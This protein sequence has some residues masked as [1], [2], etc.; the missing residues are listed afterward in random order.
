M[1]VV[2]VNQT[3][4][5][6][7]SRI[8]LTSAG[9]SRS[10]ARPSRNSWPTRWARLIASRTRWAHE[11]WAVALRDGD[12]MGGAAVEVGRGLALAVGVAGDP[13]TRADGPA[14]APTRLTTATRTALRARAI[15]PPVRHVLTRPFCAQERTTPATAGANRALSRSADRWFPPALLPVTPARW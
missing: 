11:T 10:S 7:S 6:C 4:P 2:A 13:A 5:T 14:Q 12:E 15:R 1:E 8:A 3:E 9:P